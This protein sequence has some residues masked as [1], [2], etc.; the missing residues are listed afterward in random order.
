MR[1]ESVGT[2]R[3]IPWHS[4]IVYQEEQYPNLLFAKNGELYDFDGKSV[5][6][7]GGAYS[8][9]KYYRLGRDLQW[10]A[11]EQPTAA[12]K[13]HIET[14]LNEIGR[15][16]YVVLSHTCPYQYRPTVV[17]LAGLDQSTIDSST[18]EWLEQI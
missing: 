12:T 7:I 17:F 6:V 2:Y 5:F 10:F 9:Y 1:P 14:R 8:A 15:Q 16:V 18:E 3:E 4:G 13:R 11:D